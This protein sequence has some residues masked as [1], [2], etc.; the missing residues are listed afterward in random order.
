MSP[1]IRP[2]PASVPLALSSMGPATVPLRQS[3][4]S[5]MTVRPVKANSASN[6]AVPCIDF[7]S[8]MLPASLPSPVKE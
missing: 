5:L 7:H 2:V 3:V 1:L 8:S 6:D 4:P